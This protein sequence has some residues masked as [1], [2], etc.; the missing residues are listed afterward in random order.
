[1]IPQSQKAVENA[2]APA[3][4]EPIAIRAA[5]TGSE[6]NRSL[7]ASDSYRRRDDYSRGVYG[8]H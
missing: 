7:A 2:I 5:R 4:G 1:M 3:A 6:G 8:F